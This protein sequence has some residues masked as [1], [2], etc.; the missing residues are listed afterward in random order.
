MGVTLY[1]PGGN[2]LRRGIKCEAKVFDSH[3]FK[4]YLENGWFISPEDCQEPEKELTEVEI[5]D[6][7]KTLKIKNWYNKSIDKLKAEI[8]ACQQT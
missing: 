7:A 6:Q 2:H 8:A 3:G 5:R 4:T 1:R